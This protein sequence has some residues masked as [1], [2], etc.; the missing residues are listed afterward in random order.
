MLRARLK[1]R[2]VLIVLPPLAVIAAGCSTVKE[3]GRQRMILIS[4][5]QE[6]RLG[7]DAYQEILAAERISTDERMTAVM[8]R[9]G[10]RIAAV[11]D[12]PDFDWEFSLLES[13]QVN[14]FCLPGGKIAVYTGILPVM[15]NEAGMAVVIGH[16]VAHATARHGAERL[17][18][19]LTL[20]MIENL[21]SIGLGQASPLMKTAV[22]QAFGIGTGVGVALPYSRVHELEADQIGLLYAARAGYDPRE[23]VPLWQRMQAQSENRSPECLSTHPHE[24]RRIEKLEEHMPAA[25]EAFEQAEKQYGKGEQW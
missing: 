3:T 9:V 20:D 24:E 6:K 1:H 16:E 21:L 22:L 14:A 19:G 23:A 13:E 25:L 12:Q 17:S 11:A 8:T 5:S 18:Q 10:G 2:C 7:L 4:G 15:Q